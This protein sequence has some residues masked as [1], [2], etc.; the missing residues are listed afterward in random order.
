M[1]Y[2][3]HL[4]YLRLFFSSLKQTG[5]FPST[6]R[7]ITRLR[8]SEKL[9][10]LGSGLSINEIVDWAHIAAH[11]S[12]GFNF[13]LIH[14]FVPDFYFI[15]TPGVDKVQSPEET[16]AGEITTGGPGRL[17]R[18]TMK[19]LIA[20][21]AEDYRETR[22]FLKMGSGASEIREVLDQHKLS[23]RPHVSLNFACRRASRLQGSR[24]GFPWLSGHREVR[25]HGSWYGFVPRLQERAC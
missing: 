18:E 1:T 6:P 12:V 23:W 17:G 9:F 3:N 16:S 2:Q 7:E 4:R 15:E 5:R 20:H 22:L 19:R 25:R 14:D 13:W 8:T 24:V 11:D 21:R 10:I